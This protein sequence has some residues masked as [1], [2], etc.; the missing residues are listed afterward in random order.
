MSSVPIGLWAGFCHGFKTQLEEE[1]KLYILQTA[2][3]V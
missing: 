1:E 2:S 3:Q